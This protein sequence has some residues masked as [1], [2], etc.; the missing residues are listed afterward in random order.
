MK[1]RVVG[2][3]EYEDSSVTQ[4]ACSDAAWEAI[5][6]DIRANGYLF[7]GWHH[8]EWQNCAPVLNDGKKRCLTQRGFGALMARAKGD[9]SRMGYAAYAFYWG[10]GEESSFV[11]PASSR[12]FLPAQFEPQENLNECFSLPVSH[13]L[14]CRAKDEGAV[15]IPW[16]EA[17]RFLDAGDTLCL[18]DG[19]EAVRF[20]VESAERCKDLTSEQEIE[21]QILVYQMTQEA[22][23]EA[24]RRYDEAPW[25]WKLSLKR[26]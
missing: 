15:S 9:E 6:D 24:D 25:V 17:L 5:I 14:L 8:Q 26:I 4:A 7:S 21:I 1:Y 23:R 13:D 3:T 12:R 19:S 10:H 20:L 2:W 22:S 16:S 11:F 18:Q